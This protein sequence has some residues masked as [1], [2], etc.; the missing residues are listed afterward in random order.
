MVVPGM[1]IFDTVRKVILG[2]GDVVVGVVAVFLVDADL[3]ARTLDRS[4]EVGE[5]VRVAGQRCPG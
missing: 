4:V 3:V 5:A 2:M 1:V